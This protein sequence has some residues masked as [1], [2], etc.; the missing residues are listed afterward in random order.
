MGSYLQIALPYENI[1]FLILFFVGGSI[2]STQAQTNE[3]ISDFD[4]LVQKI[5]ADYPGY[6]DKVTAGTAT[7]LQTLEKDIRRKL[8]LYPDS[9]GYYLNQYASWFKDKHLRVRRTMASGNPT[10]S[11]IDERRFTNINTP[12]LDALQSKTETIEGIWHTFR[13][14]IA[15]VKENDNF[16]GVAIQY[17]GYEKDQIIFQFTP[18]TKGEFSMISYPAQIN[19][20]FAKGL[21]SL[22]LNDKVLELHNDTRFVRKTGYLFMV[23]VYFWVKTN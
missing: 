16:I 17:K 6:S 3:S 9:C 18:G 14:D 8:G 23:F 13:G 10:D 22:R 1:F 20:I 19:Y 5:K 11:R 7:A 21:A 4:Y 2:I 15:I 12:L